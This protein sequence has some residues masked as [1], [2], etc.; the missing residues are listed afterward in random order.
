MITICRQF[1]LT[2]VQRSD[3]TLITMPVHIDHSL[4]VHSR[5][6][7]TIYALTCLCMY[8]EQNSRICILRYDSSIANRRQHLRFFYKKAGLFYY[9]AVKKKAW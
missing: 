7:S 2:I 1:P 5:L 8:A 9:L 4:P 6:I 3:D